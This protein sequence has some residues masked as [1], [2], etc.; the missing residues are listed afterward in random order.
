MRV[1]K[2][3]S[4][5]IPLIKEVIER[6]EL[7]CAPTDTLYG[8]LGSPLKREAVEKVYR[9]KGRER[10]KPLIIL[11][12]S[13]P[14]MEELG[15]DLTGKLRGKLRELYPAPLTL[16][17]PLKESSPLR[18]VFKR[19]DIGVRI[20]KEPFLLSLIEEVGPLFAPSANPS[21]LEPAKSCEECRRYF[22]G[23]VSL[24]VEG[25]AGGIPSTIVSLLKGRPEVLREGAFPIQRVMEVF[26][27]G[28]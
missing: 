8:L 13:V 5:A 16:I 27:E 28:A 3:G 4:S 18:E 21:G 14:Q 6:G 15:V 22:E 10:E 20:P 25:E 23:S 12:S 17:L 19:K 9:V 24:C 7:I 2:R 26:S 1:V 11:F